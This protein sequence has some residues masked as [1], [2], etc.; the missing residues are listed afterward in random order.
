MKHPQT[1]PPL[2]TYP[3]PPA[4]IFGTLNRDK[5]RIEYH[6]QYCG[7]IHAHG[8]EPSRPHDAAYHRISHCRAPG[9]PRDHFITPGPN[10][11]MATTTES[12]TARP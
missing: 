1:S 7:E 2:P 12:I 10:A 5:S 3:T 4:V 6:C 9:A 11:P 8:W